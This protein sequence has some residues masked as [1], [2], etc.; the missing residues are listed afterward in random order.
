MSNNKKLKDKTKL[1]EQEK[2]D[3]K[4]EYIMKA[5]ILLTG[6]FALAMF[7]L[8]IIGGFYKDGEYAWYF[9]AFAFVCAALAIVCTIIVFA[10]GNTIKTGNPKDYKIMKYL[11]GI[12]VPVRESC[13]NVYGEVYNFND[14]AEDFY[15]FR[16]K[17][18][19]LTRSAL[20][21]F[22]YFEV[23]ES[24]NEEAYVR[25]VTQIAELNRKDIYSRTLIVCFVEKQPCKYVKEIMHSPQ[26]YSFNECAIFC[27]YNDESKTLKVN[28]T[29]DQF[30]NKSYN[31]AR[32]ELSKIFRFVK[33]QQQEKQQTEESKDIV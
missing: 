5:L 14:G 17:E 27:T 26:Y 4:K 7:C 22:A 10:I 25:K 3:R 1:S 29:K 6:F 31:D 28:K 9:L 32:R 2:K 20:F 8:C 15:C 13:Q 33:P 23:D 19:G 16:I 11:C 30:G 21:C 12:D 18:E 24:F